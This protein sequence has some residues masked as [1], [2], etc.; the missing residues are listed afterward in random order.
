MH[1]QKPRRKHT[2]DDASTGWWKPRFS[3]W[4]RPA[5]FSGY[6]P[7][8]FESQWASTWSAHMAFQLI[9]TE[10]RLTGRKLIAELFRGTLDAKAV[11]CKTV[12]LQQ[13]CVV[14]K[15]QFIL[16]KFVQIILF[17]VGANCIVLM[18][19]QGKVCACN[20][21]HH[22]LSW[23]IFQSWSFR[24]T[25]T[26]IR[27]SSCYHLEWQVAPHLSSNVLHSHL[28]LQHWCQASFAHQMV[29]R[30]QLELLETQLG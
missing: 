6:K 28:Q 25:L 2:R 22:L 16:L 13:P 26:S 9:V 27:H 21:I 1:L 19:I 23:W 20:L 15:F 4:L 7:R 5:K 12:I 14:V 24:R 11:I 18:L 8:S 29:M 3:L 17:K 10:C 30:L